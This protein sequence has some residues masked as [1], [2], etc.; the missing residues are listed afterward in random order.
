MLSAIADGIFSIE[1]IL[2]TSE[3][4]WTDLARQENFLKD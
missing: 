4:G 1:A 2:Q 3:S